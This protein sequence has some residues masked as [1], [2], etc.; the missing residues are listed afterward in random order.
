[1]S[2]LSTLVCHADDVVTL[3]GGRLAEVVEVRVIC[4][5]DCLLL[6]AEATNLLL[7][8]GLLGNTS[9]RLKIS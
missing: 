4:D 2:R 1:M 7:T 8:T 3:V 9:C 5:D 6:P